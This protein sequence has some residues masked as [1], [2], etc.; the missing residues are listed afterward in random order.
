[1]PCGSEGMSK[2]SIRTRRSASMISSVTR[3]IDGGA[4]S[5]V[6]KL[7]SSSPVCVLYLSKTRALAEHV[8]ENEEPTLAADVV[9]RGP[10]GRVEGSR[11]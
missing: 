8:N 2:R 6:V 5:K 3:V 9:G 1:M 7:G 11:G 10:D 4:L